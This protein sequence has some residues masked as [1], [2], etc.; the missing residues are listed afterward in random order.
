MDE[1]NYESLRTSVGKKKLMSGPST[2][3][4]VSDQR[5]LAA[6]SYVP[7]QLR[8]LPE[9][10]DLSDPITKML[11]MGYVKESSNMFDMNMKALLSASRN[12]K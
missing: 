12:K 2:Y 6:F 8:D 7:V 9:E 4:M 5:Y 11:F 10:E 1:D 3:S